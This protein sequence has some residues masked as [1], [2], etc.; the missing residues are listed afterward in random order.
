MRPLHGI[1]R[2]PAGPRTDRGAGG[3][4][5][6]W[7]PRGGPG[8]RSAP[9]PQ[10][11]P[12]PGLKVAVAA[13]AQLGSSLPPKILLALLR[14]HDPAIRADAC[15]CARPTP[16]IVALLIDLL[17]DLHEPVAISAALALG[18]MSRQGARP[19]LLQMLR[20]APSAE[21]I[22]TIAAVADEEYIVL[23]GRIARTVPEQ[24]AAALVA[25]T[26]IDNS[27]AAQLHRSISTSMG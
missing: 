10:S 2:R 3:T 25:L 21:A 16:E 20:T 11:D 27:R 22:A 17:E 7:R 12:G 6:D 24:S 8:G 1:R 15:R 19:L 18:R 14:H 26:A 13:A 4:R 23:I 5:D 9:A